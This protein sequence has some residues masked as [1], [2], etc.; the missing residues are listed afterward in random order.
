MR[1][2]EWGATVARY[3][4]GPYRKVE[5][6]R[7]MPSTISS[8]WLPVRPRTKGE[9]PPWFVFWTKTPVI[10]V[11]VSGVE[12]SARRESS[13]LSRDDADS[14]TSNAR[15]S[16]PCAVTV[17]ASSTRTSRGSR[18]RWIG[19]PPAGASTSTRRY[20]ARVARRRYRPGGTSASEKAPSRVLV[21]WCGGLRE[22]EDDPVEGA[23]RAARPGPS[24]RTSA[25]T[26]GPARRRATRSKVESSPDRAAA[27]WVLAILP[28]GSFGRGRSRTGY[29]LDRGSEG[30]H[31]RNGRRTRQREARPRSSRRSPP[32]SPTR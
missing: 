32:A 23:A 29:Y 8:T 4:L 11:S 15:R 20:P 31:R 18:T 30:P 16:S 14:G 1:S 26:E 3:W 27:P 19:S 10:P 5:L 17:S 6:L 13:S 25:A 22:L 12:R 2:I 28:N 7:R 9:P 24:R 21:A